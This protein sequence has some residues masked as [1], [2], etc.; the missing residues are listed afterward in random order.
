M[1]WTSGTANNSL[2]LLEIF[3]DFVST[4]AALVTAGEAWQ[5]LDQV[6]APSTNRPLEVY[7]KAPGRG[8]D[9]DIYLNIAAFFSEGADYYNWELR[10]AKG[11]DD[12][13]P[14]SAQ[15]GTSPARYLH[16]WQSAT[17]YWIVANGQRA[18]VVAKVSTNYMCMYLGYG[19]PTGT[20]AQYP[21]PVI[22]AGGSDSA[23]RRWSSTDAVH[24]TPQDPGTGMV[25]HYLD[26][27]WQTIINTSGGTGDD[28]NRVSTRCVWPAQSH[29]GSTVTNFLRTAPG[30]DHQMLDCLICANDPGTQV[31]AFLDGLYWI[32][33][34]NNAAENLVAVGGVNH[35]VVQN[36]FRN[37]I[38]HYFAVALA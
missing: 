25:L 36:I 12:T 4:N 27:S 14:M 9:Q 7:F 30:G 23:T 10:G 2:H 34:F 29:Q 21:Y 33:G 38:Q 18:I 15:P 28:G 6:S 13:M 17:P 11:H 1:A 37:G 31:L 3:R 24:R 19:L 5:V 8:G 22:V 16:L 20:P 32:S 26:G 35:L